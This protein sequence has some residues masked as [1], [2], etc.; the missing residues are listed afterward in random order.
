MKIAIDM[1]GAQSISRT[2]GIGRYTC[3]IVESLARNKNGHEVYIVFNGLF[4]DT[5]EPLKTFLAPYISE[6]NFKTWSFVGPVDCMPSENDTRRAIAEIMRETFLASLQPDM[7]LITSLIEGFGDNAVHSIGNAPWDIPVAVIFYDVIP[8]ILSDLYL[9]GN[10]RFKKVYLEKVEHLK[11]AEL[12][13]AISD[14]ARSEAV[15]YLSKHENHVTNI[16][17]AADTQFTKITI[18]ENEKHEL[19]QKLNIHKLFL[20]YSGGSDDRKNQRKLIDAYALLPKKIRDQYQ[21]VLAG[22]LPDFHKIQFEEHISS[23]GLNDSQVIITGR[24]SDADM[25]MLYNLCT[26]YVFPSLHEGFGLPVLEAMSCGA[27]VIGS[28]VSSIPEVIGNPDALFDPNSALS[29]STK[30]QT[31]LCNPL[32]V[33]A[34]KSHAIKQVKKFTWDISGVR[35]INA[36]QASYLAHLKT[37]ADAHQIRPD[38]LQCRAYLVKAVGQLAK[39]GLNDDDIRNIALAIDKNHP[40]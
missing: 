3:A 30:I 9:S 40:I 5:I 38:N 19:Y 36:L 26:L 33:E 16:S 18:S 4:P 29:M 14:S 34:L 1:Q 24:I 6:E 8:L 23:R 39:A 7:I 27:P 21:L 37:Q 2:R 17:G 31:I 22:G 10:L 35:T 25:I 28:N 32:E 13:L 11:N 20:M 15:Q 12:L